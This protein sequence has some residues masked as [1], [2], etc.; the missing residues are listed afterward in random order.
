MKKKVLR[1]KKKKKGGLNERRG[2]WVTGYEVEQI[3]GEFGFPNM[4]ADFLSHKF[5]R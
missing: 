2:R 5:Y 1:G 4:G 3:G